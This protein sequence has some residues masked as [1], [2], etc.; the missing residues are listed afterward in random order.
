[1]FCFSLHL[2]K[3]KLVKVYN[4]KHPTVTKKQ[5]QE[6]CGGGGNTSSKALYAGKTGTFGM[7]SGT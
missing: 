6:I 2:S 7:L 5:K 4:L 3:I 1:M